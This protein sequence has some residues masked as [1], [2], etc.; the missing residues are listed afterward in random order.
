MGEVTRS[1]TCKDRVFFACTEGRGMD[2][3]DEENG[4]WHG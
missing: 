3:N 1:I 2:R 4:T